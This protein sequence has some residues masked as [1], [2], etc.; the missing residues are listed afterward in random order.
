MVISSMAHDL[1]PAYA[2]TPSDRQR[3]FILFFIGALIDLVVLGLFAEYSGKVYVDTF[4]TALLAAIVLQIL[5]KATIIVEHRI[6]ALFKGK[7]GLGW[8]SLKFVCAWLILFG[9]KFVILGALG[10]VFEE[11]VRFEGLLHGLVWVIVVAVTMVVIEELVA[12]FY[13]R[14]A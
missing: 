9:S 13:R 2:S 4:T 3:L 5:L 10:F 7:A 1:L 11:D 6:L 12:R 14:L 8:L